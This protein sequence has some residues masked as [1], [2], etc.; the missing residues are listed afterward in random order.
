LLRKSLPRIVQAAAAEDDASGISLG[1]RAGVRNTDYFAFRRF[2]AKFFIL[3]GAKFF[4][5]FGG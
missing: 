4:I 1:R 3:F 2:G 5:L